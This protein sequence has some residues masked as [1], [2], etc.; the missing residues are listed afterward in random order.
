MKEAAVIGDRYGDGSRKGRER[1]K[2]ARKKGMPYW[3]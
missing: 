3:S 2:E 1:K